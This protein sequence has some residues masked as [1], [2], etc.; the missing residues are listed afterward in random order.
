MAIVLLLISV[1]LAAYIRR[2]APPAW[3]SNRYL[4]WLVTLLPPI[5]G[6]ALAGPLANP[7]T[8][9]AATVHLFL[10]PLILGA[11]FASAERLDDTPAEGFTWALLTI[12]AAVAGCFAVAAWMTRSVCA[13]FR[14]PR[15]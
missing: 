8:L 11:A 6:G 3:L 1:C 5:I 14:N 10:W 15:R 7:R 2:N 4:V 13:G 12:P 9:R